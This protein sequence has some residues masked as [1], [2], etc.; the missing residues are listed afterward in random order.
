MDVSGERANL[1][2]RAQ[3]D[4]GREELPVWSLVSLV[5]T[6]SSTLL[7]G[8]LSGLPLLTHYF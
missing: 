1:E 3:K 8:Y 7:S 4:K 2:E 6:T 5:L